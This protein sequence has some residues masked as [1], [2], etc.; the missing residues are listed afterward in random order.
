MA[1]LALQLAYEEALEDL[2]RLV[3]VAYVL[4]CFGCVLAS[5]I[6]KDFLTTPIAPD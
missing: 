4:E 1:Y 6:E 5:Y 2:A 3:A